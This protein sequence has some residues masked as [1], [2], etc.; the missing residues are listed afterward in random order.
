MRP[1][2]S[3]STSRAP[4]YVRK[5]VVRPIGNAGAWLRPFVALPH[6]G[7]NADADPRAVINTRGHNFLDKY[8]KPAKARKWRC[9]KAAILS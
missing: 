2:C 9:R 5:Q 7:A 4:A 1:L 3:P 8:H 6:A